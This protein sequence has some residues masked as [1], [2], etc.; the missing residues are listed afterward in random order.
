MES[1]LAPIVIMASNRGKTK[2]RGT[3]IVS[4]HGMPLDL[5]D[6]LLIIPTHPYNADEVKEILKIR[7]G[8]EGVKLEDAALELLTKFGTEISLRYAVQLMAPAAERAQYFGRDTVTVE[9]VEAVRDRFASIEES[10][11]HLAKWEEKFM[12]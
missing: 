5:L 1:E 2:I 6:R 3:D 10:I 9:D 4:P 8:E 7:A 11:E 12:K